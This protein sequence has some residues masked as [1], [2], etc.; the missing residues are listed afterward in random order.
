MIRRPPRSTL[1]PY[2][3]LFRSEKMPGIGDTATIQQREFFEATHAN[4]SILIAFLEQV[5]GVVH[6]EVDA[7]RNFLQAR[8]RRAMFKTP[9]R[10]VEVQDALEALLVGCGLQKGLDYDRETGR[11]KLSVKESVPDFV[12]PRWST[13]LEVKLV[14]HKD[15][16][17]SVVD[18]INADIRSYSTKYSRLIFLV[19]DVGTIRDEDEFK[20]GLEG[21]GETSVLV[22]KH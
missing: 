15:R 11:T 22:V 21:A 12:F 13:A 1:F 2:T 18:E 19:Y 8:L 7:L 10:E 16:L 14:K 5:T 9:D 3:T 4:L 17:G 6:D 20:S